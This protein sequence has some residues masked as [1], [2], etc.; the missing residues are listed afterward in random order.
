MKK[1]TLV[2]VGIVIL[3][4]G[5][6]AVFVGFA[7]SN[8]DLSVFN[9]RAGVKEEKFLASAEITQL[10]IEDQDVSIEFTRSASNQVEITYY[11][12]SN[13]AYTFT[14]SGSVLH[15]KK[16]V[17]GFWRM[18]MFGH[19]R[20]LG[21]DNRLVV[22]L[23]QNFAGPIDASTTNGRIT[24]NGEA[25]EALTLRS[26]NGEINVENTSAKQGIF[27][28]TSNS[29]VALIGSSAQ[30][31][32]IETSNA[33]VFL[34]N[35]ATPMLRARTSNGKMTLMRMNESPQIYLETSN[36][37]ISLADVNP[38]VLDAKTSNGAIH[39]NIIGR[40]E[41]FDIDLRTSNSQV[42]I[43][44]RVNPGHPSIRLRTSNARIDVTFTQPN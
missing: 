3:V 7:M 38:Q 18:R 2:I 22:A 13:E 31:I 37:V 27:L 34:D 4:L 30:D 26:R 12:R 41:D 32:Q 33:A 10:Q 11:T 44:N 17:T 42:N 14:E 36:A 19:M 43:P 8:Y 29:P 5:L 23:P 21:L 28:Q 20:W 1:Y 16:E 9:D 40:E 25:L 24:M 6:I 39:A 15:V 35:V